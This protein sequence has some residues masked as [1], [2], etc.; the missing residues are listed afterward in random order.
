[1]IK[2]MMH[3][4][5][6]NVLDEKSIDELRNI[7]G[8]D[9]EFVRE[10]VQLFLQQL[11]ELVLN[12]KAALKSQEAEALKR[13][14][15]TLK[16]ASRNI[17]ALRLG[18]FCEKIESNSISYDTSNINELIDTLDSLVQETS[19]EIQNKFKI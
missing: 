6:I 16:G 9:P 10:V 11:P 14:A 2:N 8:N 5:D 17:G 12:L 1:M 18:A 15:H 13:S 7:T 19:D 3:L 4:A